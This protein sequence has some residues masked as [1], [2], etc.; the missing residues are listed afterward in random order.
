MTVRPLLI[1]PYGDYGGSEM[2]L[3]RVLRALDAT[4]ESRVVVLTR[5]PFADMLE[6]EGFPVHVEHL[7]GKSAVRHFPRVAR[8]MA[9]RYGGEVRS[10][11]PT[12]PRRRSSASALR[13]GWTCRSSG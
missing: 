2:M 1:A 7:P 8:E 12:E 3:M 5:G 11:M 9:E 6:E 4:V 10:C 13:A